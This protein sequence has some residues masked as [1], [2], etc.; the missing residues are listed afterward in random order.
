M[1]I[2][3]ISCR[4]RAD[5]D[6]SL[7]FDRRQQTIAHNVRALAALPRDVIIAFAFSS[8]I[9]LGHA[10]FVSLDCLSAYLVSLITAKLQTPATLAFLGDGRKYVGTFA[11]LAQ[12]FAL[13]FTPAR[14]DPDFPPVITCDF[15]GS[16]GLDRCVVV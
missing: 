5:E 3:K 16:F 6:V 1:V 4:I 11:Q 2:A 12:L 7:R 13:H 9:Q 8:E 15:N 10:V 14:I